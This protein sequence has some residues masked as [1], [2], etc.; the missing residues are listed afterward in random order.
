MKLRSLS[1]NS[2]I[3]VSVS[4]L[5]IPTIGLPAVGK[6]VD[7]SWDYINRSQ[8]HNVEIGTVAVQLFSGST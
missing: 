5:N 1:P 6:E 8:T 4:D 2:Y 7:R 3:H